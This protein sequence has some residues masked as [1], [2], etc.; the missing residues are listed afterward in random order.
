MC[1]ANIIQLIAI[2][3]KAR[4]RWEEANR[5]LAANSADPR[6]RDACRYPEEQA[7]LLEG[8]LM[9]LRVVFPDSAEL[10]MKFAHWGL[11][12]VEETE[13]R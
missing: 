1:E 7:V 8:G 11:A 3:P 4:C 9:A 12:L 2:S 5:S 10:E 6:Y 13:L